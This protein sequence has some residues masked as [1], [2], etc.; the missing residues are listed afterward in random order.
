MSDDRDDVDGQVED[1]ATIARLADEV[2]PQLIERLTKSS[3]GELEVRENGWR[4]RLRRPVAD[5]A[6]LCSSR[7][8]VKPV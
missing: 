7:V 2:V 8:A 3:L 5:G 4:I 6:S 1:R